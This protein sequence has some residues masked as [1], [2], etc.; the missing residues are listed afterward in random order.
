M[1]LYSYLT[2]F[3]ASLV[4]W[5]WAG[6]LVAVVS[7]IF[8]FVIAIMTSLLSR[9]IEKGDLIGLSKAIDQDEFQRLSREIANIE[10]DLSE[11]E[12]SSVLDRVGIVNVGS[13]NNSNEYGKIGGRLRRAEKKVTDL[14][15]NIGDTGESLVDLE[16]KLDEMN[17]VIGGSGDKLKTMDERL[18]AQAKRGE[19]A[20]KSVDGYED[21]FRDLSARANADMS[22]FNDIPNNAN[23][24]GAEDQLIETD[25][26][27]ETIK[28]DTQR[29]ADLEETAKRERTVVDTE[30]EW[31]GERTGARM[32]WSMKKSGTNSDVFG[33]VIANDAAINDDTTLQVARLKNGSTFYVKKAYDTFRYVETKKQSDVGVIVSVKGE[34]DWTYTFGLTNDVT[35]VRE[36]LDELTKTK[37]TAANLLF[38]V[39]DA[40]DQTKLDEIVGDQK[41]RVGIW[42]KE[43]VYGVPIGIGWLSDGIPIVASGR[44][45]DEEQ[46]I[47]IATSNI[48]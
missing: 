26:V 15:K 22:R 48:R 5:S 44:R 21:R 3:D 41:E 35:F 46:T 23:I 10:G 31:L 18:D 17:R 7:I 29:V 38:V 24:A 19:A 43:L 36:W 2:E 28:A 11:V 30:K 25:R 20:K 1:A 40:L 33:G 47:S 9:R 13:T 14:E 16:S 12:R 42:T 37:T 6:T 32:M 27:R 39:G 34:G 45:S 4:N 8:L